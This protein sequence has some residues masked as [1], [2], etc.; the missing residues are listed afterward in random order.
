MADTITVK[1]ITE[2]TA[3]SVTNTDLFVVGD[4][5]GA[6]LKK[7]TFQQ[8]ATAVI[9]G[10][11]GVSIGGSQQTIKAAVDSA[12]N[13]LTNLTVYLLKGISLIRIQG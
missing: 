11:T 13:K 1:K 3:G 5:G 8:L 9:S 2:L 4:A 6:T 10:F 7:V 12:N